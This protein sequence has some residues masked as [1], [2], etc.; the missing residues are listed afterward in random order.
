[1]SHANEPVMVSEIAHLRDRLRAI[2]Q[3]SPPST[4]QRNEVTTQV[5][6]ALQALWDS[7]CARAG[8]INDDCGHL[9]LAGVGSLGRG[10]MGSR[11]DLDLVLLHDFKGSD[12]RKV[13]AL[14]QQL[15]YPI[16]DA[17]LDLDHS[18]RS[19]AQCRTVASADLPAAVG[20]LSTRPIAGESSL[21]Y[22]ASSS[23]LADWRAAA[24]RRLPDLIRSA[25]ERASHHGDLAYLTEP[26]LKE[27][28][29]GLRDAVLL[30]A[31]AATWIADRPHG[32]VDLATT[33]ILNA[34]DAVHAV[35]GRHTNRL[36]LGDLAEVSQVCGHDDEDEFL[37]SLAEAGREISYAL[38]STIRAARTALAAP[39]G[40]SRTLVIRGKRSAP[41]LR[42]V[43]E[44]IVEH[45]GELVLSADS[46]T[47][48]DPILPLRMAATSVRTSQPISPSAL[49]TLRGAP[50]LP[51]P[52]P[53][54]ARAAFLHLIG[55][56][57]AQIPVWE[58][59]DLGGIWTH[60]IPE[61]SK[62]RNRP[63]RAEIHRHTVDRHLVEVVSRVR[64]WR[65][66][67]AQPE[68]LFLGALFHDIGK[69]ATVTDHSEFGAA[70]IPD[71]LAPMGFSPDTQRDVSLLVRHHLLLSALA[72]H[73]DPD[74]PA[75]ARGLLDALEW[76][77]DLVV[78]L[79]AITE[80][81]AAS[82]A[83]SK[84]TTW[85]ASLVDRIH[86]SALAE[87]RRGGVRAV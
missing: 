54:A 74:D 34:R 67:V 84:W 62:V 27:C 14:A 59:L 49:P 38:D 25:S 29:G 47:K 65:K 78:A 22:R 87:L 24:R 72:M 4:H 64:P 83:T 50:P 20:L 10:D 81:D 61:W 52:W 13:E 12:V 68:V 73:S 77:K 18:V 80:A 69:Q 28:R 17:G 36:L 8:L 21:A 5:V 53:P 40:L 41:R 48:N 42:S 71:I 76:K 63:Q 3:G 58:A 35:T 44:G 66:E 31:L 85:R 30:D 32:N 6:Q 2:A 82:L 46:R 9:A 37:A 23:V 86:T 26:D 11:S 51:Q 33:T 60:W 79:R 39:T 43:A 56:G 16:W 55:S 70:R 57:I 15:W 19:L 75:T 1:M 7:A 45:N